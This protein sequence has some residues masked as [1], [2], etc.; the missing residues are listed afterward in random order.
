[1][2]RRTKWQTEGLQP[3]D[4]TSPLGANVTTGSKISSPGVK[5]KLASELGPV[6]DCYILLLV[7]I[8]AKAFERQSTSLTCIVCVNGSWNSKRPKTMTS[9]KGK[10]HF[11]YLHQGCQI[12]LGTTY[13]NGEKYQKMTTKR[14]YNIQNGSKTYRMAIKFASFFYC[15]ALQNLPK[16]G[17]SSLKIYYL[18]TGICMHTPLVLALCEWLT[19]T[20]KDLSALFLKL[21]FFRWKNQI[22]RFL[23][24]AVIVFNVL[25]KEAGDSESCQISE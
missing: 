8:G 9:R 15:K 25:E 7:R 22:F 23:T 5:L 11:P 2:F 17:F 21:Q 1:L 16:L 3:W 18:A 14:P 4:I 10:K 12:F 20:Q 13:Q 19:T 24:I 6:Q